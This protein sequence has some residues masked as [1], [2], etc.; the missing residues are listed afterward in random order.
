MTRKPRLAVVVSHPIPY[1]TPYYRALARD[2]RLDVRVLFASKF[3][4]TKTLDPGMG[5]EL[6]WQ[7]D[8]LGGY[9]HAFLP[10]AN[11]ITELSFAKLDNPGVGG[12]LAEF[13]PDVVLIHGYVQKTMLR[14]LA[15]CRRNAVPALMI[16]D[17][18]LH[19]GTSPA[20]RAAKRALLPLM[21]RQF[22]G[23]L[24][25]GDANEGYFAT[26]GVPRERLFRVPNVVDEGFWAHRER[27]QEERA[28]LRGAL[29]LSESDLVALYVGKMI[30]RK[31]PGDLLAALEHLRRMP[32]SQKR[33][34]VLFAGDG[35]LRAALE[36]EAAARR[37]PARFLG[38]I[39]VNELP[40]YYCAADLLAHP[41]EIETFGVIAIEAAVLGLPLVL[42]DRVGAIGPTSIAQPGDNTLV[43]PCGDAAVLARAL[44]R[45]ASEPATLDRMS[46]ASL[47]ISEELDARMS[48]R[49]TLAAI[50]RC[51]SDGEA[52]AGRVTRAQA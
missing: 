40:G 29:G 37:L 6:A 25:V 32:S 13:A 15:W 26:Y 8:L 18:S 42:S 44:H 5:I 31:R 10:G 12:A 34:V 41:A 45:L 38:F 46:E 19:S 47:R 28:R 43:H 11:R 52:I 39:N 17:S 49:N 33:I 24:C 7:T 22:S 36:Q 4:L 14:A 20:M 35:I 2:G 27:R 23:F 30:E 50:D 3:G 9:D 48:V 21:F 51:L 1:Y 16:S